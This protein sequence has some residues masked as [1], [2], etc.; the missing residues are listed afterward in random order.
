MSLGS[1]R[2]RT[3]ES[4]VGKMQH[5]GQAIAQCKPGEVVIRV[6]DVLIQYVIRRLDSE[7]TI[8]GL[9]IRRYMAYQELLSVS[10]MIAQLTQPTIFT[11]DEECAR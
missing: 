2:Y 1:L 11:W 6:V 8:F 5:L 4:L 10:E 3:A 7:G 9:Y